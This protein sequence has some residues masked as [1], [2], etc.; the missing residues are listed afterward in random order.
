MNSIYDDETICSYLFRCLNTY[1]INS[2]EVVI[3]SNG[4]W[5]SLPVFPNT[6]APLLH[7]IPDM[8]LF[9]SLQRE[10]YY[11]TTHVRNSN[12][13]E[14]IDL[15]KKS[16]AVHRVFINIKVL[17]LYYIALHALKK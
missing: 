11:R 8:K 4:C 3:G 15:M 9:R 12:P 2:Y 6:L 17:I 7:L 16:M 14:I 1:G 13:R 10:G 5:H